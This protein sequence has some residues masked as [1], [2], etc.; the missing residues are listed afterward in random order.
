[1][2]IDSNCILKEGAIASTG[3][4]SAV[5]LRSFAIPGRA[6]PLPLVFR[7]TESFAGGTS[8]TFKLQQSADNNTWSDVEGTSFTVVTAKLIR[9]AR[10][11]TRFLP[12]AI[13]KP[14]LR[15]A[16]T[17]T[18]TFTAGKIF[19]ALTREDDLPWIDALKFDGNPTPE[20]AT[21]YPES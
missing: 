10:L 5:A 13:E 19:V 16:W 9:G 14:Y 15:L 17:A 1:M 11:G 7:V 2:L 4:G 12:C 3:T 18:G 21:A 6:N 8:M 20:T